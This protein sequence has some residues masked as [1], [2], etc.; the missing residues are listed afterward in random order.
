MGS[1]I[2]RGCYKAQ[3]NIL[4]EDLLQEGEF[5]ISLGKVRQCQKS[6]RSTCTQG[7][8]SIGKCWLQERY[9]FQNALDLSPKNT[10]LNSS[11]LS[12]GGSSPVP[13][14]WLHQTLPGWTTRLLIWWPAG[15]KRRDLH[16]KLAPCRQNP[17]LELA[18]RAPAY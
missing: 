10:C 11:R 8:P 17:A 13:R 9:L 18:E 12:T 6:P 1:Y 16:L 7:K 5:F 2:Q 3:Q 15:K 4:L 14:T